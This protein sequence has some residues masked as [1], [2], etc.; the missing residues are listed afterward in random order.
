MSKAVSTVMAGAL[1]VAAALTLTSVPASAHF[2]PSPCDFIT[3]GGFIF[4]NEGERVNFGAHGGCKNGDFWGHVNF[5]HHSGLIGP[6]HVSSIEI[7][8]YLFDP[9]VPNA[10]D[11]CGIARTSLGEM[12]LFRVRLQDEGEPGRGI[13]RFGIRMNT[14]YHISTRLLAGGN[15]QLHKPNRSNFGPSP[16]PDE[17]T[18]C[19]GLA[20]P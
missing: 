16:T 9:A 13:D 11:I 1:V 4:S 2:V 10:R 19:G 7:T 20:T 5:V 18:M 12:V 14:G 17:F 3:G 6:Y 8:G 15:I